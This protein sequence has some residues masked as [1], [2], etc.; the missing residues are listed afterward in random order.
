MPLE[1]NLSDMME[2]PVTS[3]CPAVFHNCGDGFQSH[4]PG[5]Q[6]QHFDHPL[7]PSHRPVATQAGQQVYISRRGEADMLG[8]GADLRGT[9]QAGG[10]QKQERA[11]AQ[12]GQMAGAGGRHAQHLGGSLLWRPHWRDGVPVGD[13]GGAAARNAATVAS[14]G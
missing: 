13:C 7:Q 3:L 1:H 11:I 10:R 2:T 9:A 14:A 5:R 8:V 4:K 6:V 12:P